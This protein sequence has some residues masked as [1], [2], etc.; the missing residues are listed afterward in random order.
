MTT[1]LQS[2]VKLQTH[3]ENCKFLFTNMASHW[4]IPLDIV[5]ELKTFLV[6][7]FL[8]S[9]SNILQRTLHSFHWSLS[10]IFVM[11]RVFEPTDIY[12]KSC[13]KVV[14]VPV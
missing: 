4:K 2:K 6:R 9:P 13:C 3:S 7:S 14:S 1:Y 10:K 11:E 12:H 8:R 5:I